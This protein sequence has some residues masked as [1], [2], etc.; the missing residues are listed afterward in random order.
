MLPMRVVIGGVF[1]DADLGAVLQE[2]YLW[3][4]ICIVESVAW[5]CCFGELT[6]EFLA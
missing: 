5:L 2:G 6:P 3:T 1:S 4:V